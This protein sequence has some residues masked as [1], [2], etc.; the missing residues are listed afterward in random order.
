MLT[1]GVKLTSQLTRHT[2]FK[3][4]QTINQNKIA[5]GLL[6]PTTVFTLACTVSFY[7][8]CRAVTTYLEPRTEK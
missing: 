7:I 3:M 6:T 4:Y 1:F 8:A 2:L 5:K